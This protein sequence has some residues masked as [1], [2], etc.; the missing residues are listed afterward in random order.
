MIKDAAQTED[1]ISEIGEDNQNASFPDFLLYGFSFSNVPESAHTE[2]KNAFAAYF[3]QLND[4]DLVEAVKEDIITN[5]LPKVTEGQVFYLGNPL[6]VFY[7]A[8]DC[9]VEGMEYSYPIISN[10]KT[11]Q[12]VSVLEENEEHHV[13]PVYSAGYDS[14]PQLTNLCSNLPTENGTGYVISYGTEGIFLLTEDQVIDLSAQRFST[15]GELIEDRETIIKA[16]QNAYPNG[17]HI[18]I[19]EIYDPENVHM[20]IRYYEGMELPEKA[21]K[22]IP[23]EA[24]FE[25]IQESF[26]DNAEGPVY[27]DDFC[28]MYVDYRENEIKCVILTVDVDDK[29][30]I[31]HYQKISGKY[32]DA[33]EFAEGEMPLNYI[34]KRI[35][36]EIVTFGTEH[37]EAHYKYGKSIEC[38][39]HENCKKLEV[40]VTAANEESVFALIQSE[41]EDELKK[42][43]VTIVPTLH[44]VEE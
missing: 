40:Q 13:H 34:Y 11:V 10:G 25:L 36:P 43:G 22:E 14:C 33:L 2:A 16:I 15:D 24:A 27:P 17:E 35:I 9:E 29:E 8:K 41:F 30:A 4:A 18:N 7:I 39:Y 23:A 21:E 42:Y 20:A 5:T 38:N 26:S 12:W 6:T 31:A 3:N 19:K 28:E 32:A 44:A 1:L 37:A